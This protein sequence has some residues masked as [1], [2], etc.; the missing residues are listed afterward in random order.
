MTSE[1][2]QKLLEEVETQIQQALLLAE[3]DDQL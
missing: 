1:A 3:Q 2:N